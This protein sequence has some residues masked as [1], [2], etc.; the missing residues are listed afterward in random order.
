MQFEELDI[1]LLLKTGMSVWDIATHP[2]EV[3]K[4]LRQLGRSNK[5]FGLLTVPGV[6]GDSVFDE[7]AKVA[8]S[9]QFMFGSTGVVLE[10]FP[11]EGYDNFAIVRVVDL[12]LVRKSFKYGELILWP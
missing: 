1:D 9:T 10:K 4:R 2:G 12:E 5:R 11:V 8:L 3:S 7:M 6:V